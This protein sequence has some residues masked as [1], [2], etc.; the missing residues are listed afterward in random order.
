MKKY[1]SKRKS[2]FRCAGIGIAKLFRECHARIH[3]LAV[4]CVVV[5]GFIFKV[6]GL[7][8][9]ILVLCM[10][11]VLMAEAF[12][13][14]LEK[15]SDKVCPEQNPLIGDAKDLA[16]GAVLIMAITSVIAGLIIFIPKFIGC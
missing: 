16:A 3:A 1:L 13:T 8:W 11:G 12:N 15:L 7:E 14:A 9:C 2:A 4:V 6:S 5:F 10:G